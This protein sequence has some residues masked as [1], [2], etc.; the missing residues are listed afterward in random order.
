MA[1]HVGDEAV[2]LAWTRVCNDLIHRVVNL[3]PAK[4]VGVCQLPQS[5]GVSPANSAA[6][7]ERCMELGFIGCDLNPD[8]SGGRW[9]SPPLTDRHWY[10]FY[11]KMVELDVPAMVHVSSSCNANFHAAAATT[12][13]PTPPRS[14]SSSS[15]TCSRTCERCA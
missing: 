2:S 12:S 14:C 10:P 9:T 3:Y 1:H 7:L 6:E 13:T 4:L 11:E 15:R 8:P 5:P